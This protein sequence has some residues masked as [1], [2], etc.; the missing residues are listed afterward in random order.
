LSG[1]DFH[2]L[3]VPYGRSEY[4]ELTLRLSRELGIAAER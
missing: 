3:N 2:V 1:R 4:F